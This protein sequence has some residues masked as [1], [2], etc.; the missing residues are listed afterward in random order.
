[1]RLIFQRFPAA[2]FTAFPLR[3]KPNKNQKIVIKPYAYTAA[4]VFLDV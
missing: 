3:A 2:V 1:M 4:D